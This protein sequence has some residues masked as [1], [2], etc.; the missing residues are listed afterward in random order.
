[1]LWLLEQRWSDKGSVA[2]CPSETTA[3]KVKPVA[4]GCSKSALCRKPWGKIDYLTAHFLKKI[5]FKCIL[6]VILML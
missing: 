2:F 3:A 4:A 1:M 6:E 5:D